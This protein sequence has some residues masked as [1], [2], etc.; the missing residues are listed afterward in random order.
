MLQL[1]LPLKCS[2]FRA[3][4]IIYMLINVDDPT[5]HIITF[6][7][8]VKAAIILRITLCTIFKLLS[9]VSL[10]SCT[11]LCLLV[12]TNSKK[13]KKNLQEAAALLWAHSLASCLHIY[14]DKWRFYLQQEV[15]SS[16]FGKRN[17]KGNYHDPYWTTVIGTLLPAKFLLRVTA[18]RK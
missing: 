2:L 10:N 9:I 15:H 13:L 8:H 14:S 4:F 6:I 7:L 17:Q 12:K 11:A 3:I 1:S 16:I 18:T 5:V